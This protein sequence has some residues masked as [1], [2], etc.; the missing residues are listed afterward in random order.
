MNRILTLRE[1]AKTQLGEKFDLRAFHDAVLG[2][3]ALPL[4]FLT[5]VVEDWVKVRA[6]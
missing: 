1:Q 3:G 6:A 2:N 4:S 5:S